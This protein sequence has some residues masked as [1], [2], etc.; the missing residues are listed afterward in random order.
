[1]APT[2]KSIPC[3]RHGA[4]PLLSVSEAT[5]QDYLEHSADT[6]DPGGG[7]IPSMG[8]SGDCTRRRLDDAGGRPLQKPDE[9][10]VQPGEMVR[11][12]R[13]VR[14]SRRCGSF[15]ALLAA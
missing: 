3:W 12:A 5:A 8:I 15:G 9:P 10:S 11:L 4:K 1:M 2:S 7:C 13:V 6:P 14:R